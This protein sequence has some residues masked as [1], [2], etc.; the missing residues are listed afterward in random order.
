[1][2]VVIE[3]TFRKLFGVPSWNVKQGHGSFLTFDFGQP[4][5]EVGKILSHEARAQFPATRK[6]LV[7]VHGEWH[8]WIYCCSWTI[9]QEGKGLA[10]SESSRDVIQIACTV[11]DGQSLTS[12]EIEPVTGE[13]QFT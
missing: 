13:T 9:H 8:L 3:E 7:H 5:L 6:R 11:P 1:M 12:V 2:N 10:H 4:F